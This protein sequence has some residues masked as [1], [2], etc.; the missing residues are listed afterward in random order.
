MANIIN[1]MKDPGTNKPTNWARASAPDNKLKFIS[2][3]GAAAAAPQFVIEFE[4]SFAAISSTGSTVFVSALVGWKQEVV[5]DLIHKNDRPDKP[6]GY[7]YTV[8]MDGESWDPRI[9]PQ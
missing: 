3:A 6:E 8:I 1:L 7:K 4:S 2:H 5:V 9:V